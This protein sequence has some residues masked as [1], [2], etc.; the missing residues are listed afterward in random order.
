MFFL[1]LKK[2]TDVPLP[3]SLERRP[4]TPHPHESSPAFNDISSIPSGFLSISFFHLFLFGDISWNLFDVV[5]WYKILK[6]ILLENNQAIRI[7]YGWKWIIVK[8]L[9][10]R[11]LPTITLLQS[12][13]WRRE[14][15]KTFFF[16]AVVNYWW[17]LILLSNYIRVAVTSV[18]ET[19][20]T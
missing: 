15:L 18:L 4:A 5:L 8:D 11:L 14:I 3:L 7:F 2:K 16:L 6:D 1:S 12:Y 19:Q 20:S 17:L 10:S 13:C 9:G